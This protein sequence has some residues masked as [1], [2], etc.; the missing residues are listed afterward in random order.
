[1]FL[2]NARNPPSR[3]V[4]TNDFFDCSERLNKSK[5]SKNALQIGLKWCIHNAYKILQQGG[6]VGMS[7]CTL[8]QAKNKQKKANHEEKQH[9]VRISTK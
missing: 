5:P 4:H 7:R 1:M 3:I 2:V 8:Y 9:K 6:S